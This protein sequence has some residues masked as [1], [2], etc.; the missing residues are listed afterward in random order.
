MKITIL[1]DRNVTISEVQTMHSVL[2]RLDAVLGHEHAGN[3]P[4]RF[5]Y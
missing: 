5:R 1:I 3:P 2:A 4:N